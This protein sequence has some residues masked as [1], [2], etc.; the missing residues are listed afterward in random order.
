MVL[1]KVA[2]IVY[3]RYYMTL[4]AEVWADSVSVGFAL[5]L[6]KLADCGAS[7]GI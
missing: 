5:L 6:R 7:N 1:Q 3:T 2:F 4:I